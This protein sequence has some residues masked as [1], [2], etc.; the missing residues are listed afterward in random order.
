MAGSQLKKLR[1]ELK[2]QGLIGQTNVKKK[3]LNKKSKTPSETRR[4]DQANIINGIRDKFNVFDSKVN[5]VKRDVTTIQN[6]KFVKLGE[7]DLNN[8]IK[9]NSFMNNQLKM[10]YNLNKSQKSK[11]GKFLDKRFGENDKGMTSEEK[12]LQR[13]VKEREHQSKRGKFLLESDEE[14]DDYDNDDDDGFTLTH[15][16]KVL[17]DDDP[18][19]MVSDE[20][21]GPMLMDEDVVNAPPK[22][23]TKAEVMK[24]VIAKSKFYKQQ[25]QKLHDKTQQEVS[26]LDDDFQDIMGEIRDTK[27]P[28]NAFSTKTPEEIEYDNKVRELVYDKRSVPADITKTEEELRKEHE[29]KMNKLEQDRL[30]RME[31][32]R[33]TEGDDLDEFW[34]LEDEEDNAEDENG[35]ENENG[36]E[37]EDEEVQELDSS[38]TIENFMSTIQNKLPVE[39]V[40]KLVKAYQPHL[41]IGNKDKMN[42]LVGII[43]KYLLEYP[44]DEIIQIL[45]R[46]SEKYNEQLVKELKVEIEQIHK[47]IDN[48]LITKQNLIYFNL[49]GMIFSSSDKYHLIIIP[50]LILMSELLTKL[51]NERFVETFNGSDKDLSVI[52]QALLVIDVI[53]KYQ[54]FSKRYVPEIISTLGKVLIVLQTITKTKPSKDAVISLT[55]IYNPTSSTSL[56]YINKLYEQVGEV[57][58]MYKDNVVITDLID[59]W[60]PQLNKYQQLQLGNTTSLSSLISRLEKYKGNNQTR[61]PLT[62]Q[63]HRKLAIKTFQPK[64]DEN[65]NPNKNYDMNLD[66][67]EVQKLK[68]EF[69]KERKNTLKDIRKQNKF[70][71]N[72]Q[73][74]EKIKKYDEY[75]TKM[76]NIVNSI[77]TVEGQERNQYQREK[78]RQKQK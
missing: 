21:S 42:K 62:L 46:L 70:E 51:V 23:K 55:E 12:M 10:A 58:D 17:P 24:E 63:T 43:F 19:E 37:A 60:M 71:G 16:G 13:F 35:N 52:G 25:R 65:F 77:S 4:Q 22:R 76:A 73:L 59:E 26:N 8:P 53:L 30:K 2:Q 36:E 1:E 18:S 78:R 41:R 6:G 33:D 45:K 27:T 72:E 50:N 31:G 57:F 61:V 68:H 54:R 44:N 32:E 48:Q 66:R 5:R 67:Q 64:F 14:G 7:S 75:H 69:K 34:G 38:L 29:E 20:D 28:H 39:Y 11:S 3:K 15:S 40:N 56:K 74:Q 47:N 49:S 9:S